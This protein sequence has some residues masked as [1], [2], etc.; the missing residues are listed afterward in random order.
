VLRTKQAASDE[1][2]VSFLVEVLGVEPEI[3][4]S[5]TN[6]PAPAIAGVAP[7]LAIGVCSLLFAG[8]VSAPAKTIGAPC[9]VP[10]DS[11]DNSEAPQVCDAALQYLNATC[12]EALSSC[13]P[14]FPRSLAVKTPRWSE[15][16]G[17]AKERA[18]GAIRQSS[19]W[20]GPGTNGSRQ[21]VRA[22]LS[23]ILFD[24][25]SPQALRMRRA[26]LDLFGRGTKETVY[27][28]E[29]R[30]CQAIT[31]PSI[32]TQPLLALRQSANADDGDGR[33]EERIGEAFGGQYV[34]SYGGKAFL[35]SRTSSGVE[36]SRPTLNRDL[37]RSERVC[38]FVRQHNQ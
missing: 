23:P 3:A 14:T 5:L 20:Y 22:T 18:L 24:P 32:Q 29:L 2:A 8:C 36:I 35:W 13:E 28:L 33:T 12:G 37:P 21:I 11:Q 27:L 9:F 25:A 34:V 26:R 16:R 15:V 7:V 1:W 4:R 17:R 31:T 30:N 38:G 6:C 10:S 19:E